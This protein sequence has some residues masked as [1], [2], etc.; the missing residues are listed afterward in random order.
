MDTFF[1]TRKMKKSLRG[2]QCCKLFVTDEGFV[3]VVLMKSKNK[4]DILSALKPF[5]KYIVAPEAIRCDG[6]GEQNAI[7]V[8]KYC[9]GIVTTLKILEE[10][11][12]W[13]NKSE[14]Y[15]G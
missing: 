13:S 11:T 12:P 2:N 6:S 4:Y 14:L 3:Y 10:G 15:I 9:G 7:K 5:T 1:A 8:K